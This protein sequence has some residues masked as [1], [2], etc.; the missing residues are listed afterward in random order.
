MTV[1]ASVPV[2]GRIFGTSSMFFDSWKSETFT[3]TRRFPASAGIVILPFA[4]YACTRFPS[5][6]AL[7]EAPSTPDP[8]S[9]AVTT[10]FRPV[11]DATRR[12][13][14]VTSLTQ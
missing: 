7:T 1:V 2:F 6:V 9:V 5:T 8:A 11:V 3:T 12:R 14:G 10:T 4:Y 13:G